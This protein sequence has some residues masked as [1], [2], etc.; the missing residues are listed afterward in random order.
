LVHRLVFENLKHRPVRTLLSAA[1]IGVEV[2]LIL[3]LVGVS[4]GMLDDVKIRSRGTGADILVRPQESTFIGNSGNMDE[5]I[6]QAV[7]GVPH[8]ALATGTL[9]QPVGNLDSITGIHLAEFNQMSG[10]FTYLEKL[11][12]NP[13]QKPNDLIIDDVYA[14]GSKLRVG[15]MKEFGQEWRVTAVVGSGKLSR[16]F[17]EIEELQKMYSARGKVSMILVKVDDAANIPAVLASL[18][19]KL[20]GYKIYT[21]EEYAS[22]ISADNIPLLKQFT[23]VVVGI[24]VI[25]G[26]IVVFLSMYTAVL[27]R[28]REIGILKALGA[29][30]GYILAILLRETVLLAI[31]GTIAGILMTYGTKQLM[32]AF[33]PTMTQEIVPSWWYKAGLIALFGALIGALF[34]GLKAARLDPI[35]A[36]SYD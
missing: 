10:G 16:M 22:L 36:L 23:G 19:A 30:P 34:P 7:R 28:T 13:F 33:A 12:D 24:G 20:D 8:V 11:G 2:A 15:D 32:H 3:T 17:A 9:V 1:G 27:E 35:E 4:N 29:S 18:H 14:R 26:L 25:V 6:V 5:E 21:V 31:A